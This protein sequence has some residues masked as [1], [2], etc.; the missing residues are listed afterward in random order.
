MIS[1]KQLQFPELQDYRD[2]K[3]QPLQLP[4]GFLFALNGGCA[5]VKNYWIVSTTIPGLKSVI[6]AST[7]IVPTLAHTKFPA[8]FNQPKSRHVLIRPSLFIPELKRLVPLVGLIV[9]PSGGT[10]YPR[11]TQNVI[12]NI[13]PIEMLGPVSAVVDFDGEGVNVEVQVVVSENQ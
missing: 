10:L 1:G 12:D 5:I 9:P 3:F 2:V 6:D 11:L 13:F 8:P 7:G 4:L